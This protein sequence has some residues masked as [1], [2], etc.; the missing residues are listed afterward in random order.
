MATIQYFDGTKLIDVEV[1]EDFAKEYEEMLEKEKK[2]ERKE[3]RRHQSLDASMDGGF[4][5]EDKKKD[6]F[7]EVCFRVDSKKLRYAISKLNTEQQKLVY[8]VYFLG[9]RQSSIAREMGIDRTSIR[10]RLSVIRK[11]IEKYF[12]N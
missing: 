3:T 4:D 6:L 11:K 10:D 5:F 8:R 9:E 12:I 7:E 1:T 2:I